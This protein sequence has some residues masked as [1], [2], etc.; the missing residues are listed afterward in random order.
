MRHF[1]FEEYW[2]KWS[3][4]KHK[5]NIF[6]GGT[7]GGKRKGNIR[8][9]DMEA[10]DLRERQKWSWV[11]QNVRNSGC[12]RIFW[13][14]ANSKREPL[15]GMGSMQRS[16][17]YNGCA[18]YSMFPIEIF[19]DSHNN[20]LSKN[21]RIKKVKLGITLFT[22]THFCFKKQNRKPSFFFFF[23][24]ALHQKCSLT[25]LTS[26]IRYTKVN[27]PESF[28]L[29]VAGM[30]TRLGQLQIFNSADEQV[31]NFGKL[32]VCT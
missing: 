32:A 26:F 27:L 7:P 2:G 16:Y 13:P 17:K 9:H 15:I 18:N 24:L 30:N 12:R 21:M 19:S 29:V 5:G 28:S 11:T 1:I 4:M 23:G 25:T 20:P 8:G 22:Q 3:W 31:I 14:T 6:N 10:T